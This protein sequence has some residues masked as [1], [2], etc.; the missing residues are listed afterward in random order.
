MED[1]HHLFLTRLRRAWPAFLKRRT[2]RLHTKDD[3]GKVAEKVVENIL[4]DLLVRVLD[5][6]L[7]E[8]AYQSGKADMA[9]VDR[10]RV[11][12]V[13]EA[14]SPK[15]EIWPRR[16]FEAALDQANGYAK[17][18]HADIVGV[19]DGRL[20]YVEDIMDGHGRARLLV[21]LDAL[22]PDEE[23]WWLSWQG[24]RKRRN[25]I[26]ADSNPLNSVTGE[27]TRPRTRWT[28]RVWARHGALGPQAWPG[29]REAAKMLG[30]SA[31]TLS[32]RRDLDRVLAGQWTRL[33]PRQVM[34]LAKE[35]HKKAPNEVAVSLIDYA[36]EH[37]AEHE[38]AV[39]A[40]VEV[41]LVEVMKDYG[42]V[43]SMAGLDAL[44]RSKAKERQDEAARRLQLR[45]GVQAPPLQAGTGQL[46]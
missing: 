5:W 28:H 16:S 10:G 40:E 2:E 11:M 38:A 14:K 42:K 21:R 23:L 13:L 24:I 31:S 18:H 3:Q 7:G 34:T 30:V 26:A 29:L 4:E 36:R 1:A 43:R 35:Y 9:L 46:G 37:A 32:R 33:R 8:I 39:T 20:L 41:F 19:S 6:S 22:E 17:R 44:I 25:D 27:L 45:R 12:M 15:G